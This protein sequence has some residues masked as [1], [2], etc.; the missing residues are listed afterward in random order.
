MEINEVIH[1]LRN[2]YGYSKNDKQKAR[3]I[4]AGIIEGYQKVL[5]INMSPICSCGISI[6]ERNKETGTM[7]CK[8]CKKPFS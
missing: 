1:I 3:H 5:S 7:Q 6:S 4:A 8:D 2:P